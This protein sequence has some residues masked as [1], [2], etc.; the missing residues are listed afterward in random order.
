MHSTRHGRRRLLNG[1]A[2]PILGWTRLGPKGVHPILG[3]T[4]V[5]PLGAVRILCLDGAAGCSS[6]SRMGVSGPGSCSSYSRILGGSSPFRRV[7]VRNEPPMASPCNFSSVD[8]AL[9][10]CLQDFASEPAVLET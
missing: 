4:R 8:R 5:C 6:Y 7:A 2:Q 10:Q 1:F 9:S 3:R